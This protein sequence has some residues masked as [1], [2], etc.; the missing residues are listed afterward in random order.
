M[1]NLIAGVWAEQRSAAASS[2]GAEVIVGFMDY[3]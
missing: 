3:S 2:S 1:F